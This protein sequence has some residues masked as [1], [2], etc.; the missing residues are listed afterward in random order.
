MCIRDSTNSDPVFLLQMILKKLDLLLY[1]EIREPTMKFGDSFEV[2][3]SL[4]QTILE[5]Q[6]KLQED[7]QTLKD[8]ITKSRDTSSRHKHPDEKS[9]FSHPKNRNGFYKSYNQAQFDV[10]ERNIDNFG[11]ERHPPNFRQNH[12]FPQEIDKT[13][14]TYMDEK[15]RMNPYTE[16]ITKQILYDKAPAQSFFPNPNL[17]SR[18]SYQLKPTESVSFE[19]NLDSLQD[20]NL[21]QSFFKATDMIDYGFEGTPESGD[22]IIWKRV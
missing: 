6:M 21:D 7:I 16:G 20:K 8:M 4:L 19:E 18:V 13:Y 15:K 10:Q 2:V 14:L 12:F 11:E 9:D 17:L 1:R 22:K 5:N 3:Q